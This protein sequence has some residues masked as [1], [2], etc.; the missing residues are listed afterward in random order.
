[1]SLNN[2]QGLSSLSTIGGDCL[3]GYN[4][5]A[6]FNGNPSLNNFSGLE[7]LT[8]V[9]GSLII[10]D[11]DSLISLVGLDNLSYVGDDLNIWSNSSLPSLEGLQ[12]LTTVGGNLNIGKS[13]NPFGNQSLTSI[14]AL[15]NLTTIAGDLTI[16]LN[17]KLTSLAGLDNVEAGT[18]EEIVILNNEL[19]STCHINSVCDYLSASGG[20]IYIQDNASGCNNPE[21]VE[22][23]CEE[24]SVE[25]LGIENNFNITPNPCIDGVTL[26]YAINDLTCLP[27]RQGYLIFD[28]FG[29]T[30]TKV[31][32]FIIQNAEPG[33][34]E[35]E[36][37]LSNLPAGIY[38]CKLKTHNGTQTQKIIKL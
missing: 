10:A 16:K 18:I 11:G 38:F 13:M 36:N 2:F 15:N 24:V 28:L 7:N 37:D 12:N 29:L 5:D 26:Q 21:E 14:E 19:L 35:L 17:N 30:G 27:D 33:N 25:E 9:G 4:G 20:N 31:K 22:E 23:A 34:H 6:I 8:S 3:I 32:S 1:M